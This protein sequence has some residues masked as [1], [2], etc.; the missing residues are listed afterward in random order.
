MVGNDLSQTI[1]NDAGG[2]AMHADEF[3]RHT[4]GRAGHKMF[5]KPID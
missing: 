1:G 3:G 2:I 4:G 5:E